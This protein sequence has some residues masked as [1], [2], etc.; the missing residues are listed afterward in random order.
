[1]AD[2]PWDLKYLPDLRGLLEQ[3]R[4]RRNQIKAASQQAMARADNAAERDREWALCKADV[5]H[6]I[7]NWV[8]TYDPRLIGQI[9]HDGTRRSPYVRMILWP[10]QV[11]LVR[12]IKRMVDDQQEWLVEKSRDV[13]AS[14][15][16]MC[17][18]VH[19]WLFEPGFKA[20]FGSYKE[21]KVDK[22]DDPDSLFEKAR[23]ILRR[24]PDW[25]LPATFSWRQHDN[26]MRLVNPETGA[27]ITGESGESMGRGGRS[28]MQ[29][30]D[31]AGFVEHA[32]AV[33]SALAGTTDCVGWVSTAN[34]TGN[35][36]YRKLQA[37]PPERKFRLH[38]R[39]DPRKDNEWAAKKQATLTEP[40]AWA[41]E[42]D[43][44]YT[45][46][47]EGILIPAKWVAAAE[48]L[49]RSIGPPAAMAAGVVGMDV[50]GGKAKSVC[51]YR[52]GPF[53]LPPIVRGDPD[54]TDTAN[55]GL[56]YAKTMG[57][58]ALNF[59]TIG[60]GLGVKST[61]SKIDPVKYP[62]LRVIPINVGDPPT[63]RIWPDDRTSED[64]F[65]NHKGEIWWVSREAF[66]RSF[67][68]C[69]WLDGLPGGIE[70]L[71]SDLLILLPGRDNEEKGN[72]ATLINQLSLVKYFKNER[73]KIVTE[74]K[75][76]LQ[77]RGVHSP[78]YAEAF[79]LTYAEKR[80]VNAEGWIDYA[81]EQIAI[82]R[83]KKGLS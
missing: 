3:E 5:V 52:S 69:L 6:W 61:L 62:N 44:D 48:R 7:N 9:N 67:E 47:V 11:E 14:Y 70:H 25:L 68:H 45:A 12:F 4:A 24:Q 60:V 17:V 49:G 59:D 42:F 30:I 8:W 73:G 27:T 33:E 58:K 75:Q 1:M 10:R 65:G 23:I 63:T 53:C 36:F 29:V 2:S 32:E 79:V 72:L 13:G 50:G 39:D 41:S 31:E 37:L 81:R 46:S 19:G 64:L 66:K 38:W 40:T 56:D 80:R 28:T 16:S 71:L 35:L 74:S 34:G 55:W 15:I 77:R 20:T 54:T 18:A 51:S 76:Q 78:D 57:A 21:D 82:T 26:F 83:A 22:R 43:I